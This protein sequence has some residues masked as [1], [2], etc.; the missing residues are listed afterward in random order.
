MH[1][2]S[3]TYPMAICLLQKGLAMIMAKTRVCV[4]FGGVSSEHDISLMSASSVIQQIPK[5]KYEIICVGIT[6]KGRWL[7]FPGDVSMIANGEWES[8]PDCTTAIISPDRTHKGLIKIMAD[9]ET[10]ILHIDCVF[11]VLHGKNGEDGTIQG[12][13][14]IAG[15]PFAGCDTVSSAICMD[16]AFTHTVLDN[17]GIKT[18]KWAAIHRCDI[19]KLDQMIP[20]MVEKLGFPMFVKPANAGSSVGI[21]KAANEEQ[22]KDAIKIAFSHDTKVVVEKAIVGIEVE[23]A[24]MGYEDPKVAEPGEIVPCNE[25]YDYEAKYIMG[26][27][28]LHIPA[29]ISEEDTKRLKETAIKAYKA[30]GCGGLTRIDFFITPDH[31]IILNEPNTL[32]GFTSISMYPKLWEYSGVNYSDLIDRLITTAIERAEF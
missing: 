25:F 23:T 6:K 2:I 30:L 4:I 19:S 3:F 27:T 29:R 20:Q 13:F 11:P 16:K 32:P 22:L 10:S 21:N 12:L 31:E 26:T 9:G 8:H 7:Y 17:A 14:T 1:L 28:E 18:A 5:D 15:I 24:V